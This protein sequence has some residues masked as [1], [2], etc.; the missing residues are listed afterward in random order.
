MQ[1]R[2]SASLPQGAAGAAGRAEQG[3]WRRRRDARIQRR[4]VCVG[5]RSRPE[6]GSSTR[7]SHL[8]LVTAWG[9]ERFVG[10]KPGRRS[11][12]ALCG[13][14]ESCCARDHSSCVA[15][16]FRAL[17][18]PV[19]SGQH[20]LRI[21]PRSVGTGQPWAVAICSGGMTVIVGRSWKTPQTRGFP[22]GECVTLAGCS[23]L[24]VEVMG[25]HLGGDGWSLWQTART[26]CDRRE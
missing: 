15:S 5:H 10:H 24:P 7:S 11:A 23:I 20:P 19:P 17:G 14:F 22:S 6:R 1:R 3:P 16:P 26:D 9:S 8:G 4:Q 12:A 18:D 25:G 2:E 13:G 21:R